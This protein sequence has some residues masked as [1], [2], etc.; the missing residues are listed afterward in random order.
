MSD[1][2]RSYRRFLEL[3]PGSPDAE[4]LRGYLDSFDRAQPA[5]NR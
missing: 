1:A 5:S 2:I 4:K 3:E